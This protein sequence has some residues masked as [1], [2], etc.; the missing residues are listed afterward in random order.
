MLTALANGVTIPLLVGTGGVEEGTMGEDRDDLLKEYRQTRADLLAMLEGLTD[1]Q[2]TDPSLDGWSVAD[3]LGH[4]AVWDELRAAEVGRISA[5][6]D[7][8]WRMSP[9]KMR[10]STRLLTRRDVGSHQVRHAGN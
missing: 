7:S 3:H 10:R 5:G 9:R 2:M 4:L 6:H 8:V 1:E